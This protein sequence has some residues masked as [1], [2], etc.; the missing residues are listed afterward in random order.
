MC[1]I[2]YGG[3]YVQRLRICQAEM[4]FREGCELYIQYCKQRN[5]RDATI[6]HY[7]E[8]CNQFYK[9]FNPDLPLI[10]LNQTMYN[11]YIV[12]LRERLTNDVSINS[13]LRDLI[14][15]LHYLMSNE[16]L[17]QF[18]MQSIKVDKASVETYRYS[19]LTT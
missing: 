18:K 19:R 1:L 15:I 16:Y 10:Q 11:N 4:T 12:Y 7:R 6:E 14:T 5:L 9:F 8:S 3:D 13:Y 17:R 2:F